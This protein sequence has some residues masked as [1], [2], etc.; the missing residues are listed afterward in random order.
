MDW[1]RLFS[2]KRL[3]H[4]ANTRRSPSDVAEHRTEVERDFDRILFST[5]VRRL[6]DKTQVFPS[7]SADSVRTRLTHSYEASN[8]ARSIGN[9]LVRTPKWLPD[10][11][12]QELVFPRLPTL[13]ASAALAHD[14]GNPPFGHQG[15]SA[16]Q[17]W[18]QTNEAVFDKSVQ[19]FAAEFEAFDGNPQTLRL[20]ASLQGLPDQ[21]G[22][23]LT[24]ATIGALL[25]Y[26]VPASQVAKKKEEKTCA[27]KKVG[28]FETERET[29]ERVFGEL[30]IAFGQR[31]P[32]A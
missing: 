13:L 14:L 10:P 28:F 4:F 2:E 26:T 22:L 11:T 1:S 5:P 19:G 6:A 27:N 31:H 29:L 24:C 9:L 3:T 21:F 18:F 23:N 16:I 7:E 17:H 30:G 12:L 15:E 32:L 20:V 8:I 25:K